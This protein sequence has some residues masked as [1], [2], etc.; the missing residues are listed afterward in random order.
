MRRKVSWFNK[1]FVLFYG[2]V[3]VLC[4]PLMFVLRLGFSPGSTLAIILKLYCRKTVLYMGQ[5]LLLVIQ[6][7]NTA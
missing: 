3:P 1:S 4:W 2:L 6:K 5:L 7:Y